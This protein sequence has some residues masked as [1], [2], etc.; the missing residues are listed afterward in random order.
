MLKCRS[1]WDL[2]FCMYFQQAFWLSQWFCHWVARACLKHRLW[3]Y[4]I[5]W[6]PASLCQWCEF[7]IN[8]FNFLQPVSSSVKQ[9]N[10][11][12]EMGYSMGLLWRINELKHVKQIGMSLALIKPLINKQR[13][14]HSFSNIFLWTKACG[15]MGQ[16]LL[17]I[18]LGKYPY[19]W[20]YSWT[21]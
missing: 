3:S 21:S 10:K 4:N 19:I 17:S 20:S 13:W 2:K 8:L 7:S 18:D 16:I 15:Y 1:G 12:R 6:V 11:K 14:W 9:D 5:N